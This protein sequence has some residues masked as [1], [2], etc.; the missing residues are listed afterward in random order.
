MAESRLSEAVVIYVWGHARSLPYPSEHP[1]DVVAALGDDGLD[2]LPRIYAITS[3]VDSISDAEWPTFPG[4]LSEM[5]H[6]I[7]A[8]VRKINP[9]LDEEAVDAIGSWWAFNNR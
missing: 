1:D 6:R 8:E 9:E 3:V 7:K 2:L 5:A 4:S